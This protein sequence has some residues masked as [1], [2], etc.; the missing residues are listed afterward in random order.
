MTPSLP[1][2][3]SPVTSVACSRMISV[4]T[5]GT[6]LLSWLMDDPAAAASWSLGPPHRLRNRRRARVAWVIWT[7]CVSALD[8]FVYPV[9]VA[10]GPNHHGHREGD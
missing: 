4:D 9:A 3:T 6:F 5:L 1:V 8:G 2:S 10:T 7:G